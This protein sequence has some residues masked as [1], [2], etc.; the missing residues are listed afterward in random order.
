MWLFTSNGFLSIVAHR[1]RPGR[2]LVRGRTREDVEYFCDM[3]ACGEPAETPGADYRWRVEASV[4]LVAWFVQQQVLE[5]D[6]PSF[7]D[8]VAERQG[9]ERAH[10]YMDVWSAVRRLQSD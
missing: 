7:K 10:T 5:L 2:M 6:Y 1:E 9:Y 3:A 4:E 8:A